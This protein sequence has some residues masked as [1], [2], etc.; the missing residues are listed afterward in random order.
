MTRALRIAL[1]THSTN[2]RGGVVHA[3]AL[4]DALI[5][6]GHEVA[7]HAPDPEGG[8]FFR[9]TRCR[10]VSVKASR[11][12]GPLAAMVEMRI[13]DYLR[14]FDERDGGF[15]IYHAG[16]GISGNALACLK[17]QGKIAGFARTVHHID[18]FS[19][20]RVAGLQAHAI[21]AA[22]ILF[23][24]SN[25]WRE[26][27]RRT[28]DREA[29]VVGNGVDHSFFSSRPDPRDGVLKRRLGLGGGPVFVAVGGVEE[30]KNTLRLLE[31]FIELRLILPTA[32]LVIAG[33]ASVLDHSAYRARFF[34][35]LCASRLPEGAV[36]ITGALANDD[37]PALFRLADAF[38]FPSLKEGFGLVVL[39][40][41]ACGTPVVTSWQRPFTDYLREN[42]AVWCDPLSPANIAGAMISALAPESSGR[43]AQNGLAAAQRHDWRRAAEAHIPFYQ[44]LA[45]FT[46]A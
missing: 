35:Q 10:A 41:M 6:L 32:Q 13:A 12:H 31:A 43:L 11:Y 15:D 42:E 39:E 14:H 36:V 40:A 23:A 25:L 46:H 20:R 3:L 27:L 38:V 17:A 33:G 44:K 2:P 34:E 21:A 16:D 1:L 8:G 7:V 37:M 5:D 29:H 28:F 26:E 30:R 45:A 4:G 9:P 24:V 22:D 19:D 18:D